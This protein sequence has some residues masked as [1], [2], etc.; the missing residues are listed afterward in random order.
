MY[1]QSNYHNSNNTALYNQQTI[2][3]G[4]MYNHPFN[5]TI[6]QQ[7]LHQVNYNQPYYQPQEYQN[8]YYGSMQQQELLPAANNNT[9]INQ[10]VSLQQ[11]PAE[12]FFKFAKFKK[13]KILKSYKEIVNYI[14]EYFELFFDD[15]GYLSEYIEDDKIGRIFLDNKKFI[16]MYKEVAEN[17]RNIIYFDPFRNNLISKM[18][19]EKYLERNDINVLIMYI[20][21]NILFLKD[22]E[23]NI[24]FRSS[25]FEQ[26]INLTYLDIF[27]RLNGYIIDWSEWDNIPE[28]K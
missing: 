12:E 6:Q 5:N 4:G 2:G 13:I 17:N 25:R 15:E 1:Q 24:I 16:H 22:F 14:K 21:D 23:G 7:P 19:L 27:F 11:E 3:V 9:I 18:I 26:N 10:E 28:E 8:N 20:S